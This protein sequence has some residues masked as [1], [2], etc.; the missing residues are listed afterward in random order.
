MAEVT[1]A[2]TDAKAVIGP[3]SI[4]SAEQI[5]QVAGGLFCTYA[6]ALVAIHWMTGVDFG[7]FVCDDGMA[8]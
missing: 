5:E 2:V 7:S 1:G 8:R 4:L 3:P 6:P